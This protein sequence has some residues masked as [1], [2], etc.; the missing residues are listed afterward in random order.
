VTGAPLAPAM[1]GPEPMR[2]RGADPVAGERRARLALLGASTLAALLVCELAARVWLP[3]APAFGYPQLHYRPDPEVV[4][5]FIPGEVGF[6][7]DKLVRINAR[8]LRGPLVPYARTPGRVRILFLGD[9][10]VFGY[11]VGDDATVTARLAAALAA[12]G[13]P[14]EVVN[15]G[16]PA[17]D[18]EL[19]ARYLEHEGRRYAPDWVVVGVCWNDIVD[20]SRMRV[21]P[22]GLL[23]RGDRPGRLEALVESGPAYGVRNLLKR[24]RLAYVTLAALRGLRAPDELTRLRTQVLDGEDTED[25][26][27]GWTQVD[28]AV[29][30][31]ARLA[32]REGFRLLLVTFPIPAAVATPFPLSTYPRRVLEIGT[33]RGVPVL[34]LTTIFR[35]AYHGHESLFVAYD[36]DHPNAAG[37]ALAATAIADWLVARGV[38]DFRAGGA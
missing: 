25:V 5:S 13:V 22:D 8:G 28:A 19:E 15:A 1:P 31:M 3:A 4:F 30:R 29:A 23:G 35:P 11:G 12:R 21:S 36:G 37:H 32:T 10:L 26:E 6:T 16:V 20:V 7:A 9:S 17:Y 14:A 24:S 38:S 27:R 34:D 2:R 33:R 18:T